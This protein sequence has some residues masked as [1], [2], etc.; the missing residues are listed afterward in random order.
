MWCTFLYLFFSWPAVSTSA[1]LSPRGST[2]GSARRR[3][4]WTTFSLHVGWDMI[5][6]E[7][8]HC[9][10]QTKV[11]SHG[12]EICDMIHVSDQCGYNT[13]VLT[14]VW[15]VLFHD[16]SESK[17]WTMTETRKTGSGLLLETR[18]RRGWFWSSF[19]SYQRKDIPVPIFLFIIPHE[20]RNKS[21]FPWI[22]ED[23][24]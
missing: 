10:L 14:L 15:G 8:G 3:T 6:D 12:L 4:G 7:I 1:V 20:T 16:V 19:W 13:Q 24:R 2:W 23:T 11:V 22:N 18:K 5:S 17:W 9:S 21:P